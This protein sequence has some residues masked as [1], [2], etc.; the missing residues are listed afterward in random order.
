MI[1]NSINRRFPVV[2]AIILFIFILIPYLFWRGTWFGTELTPSQ[3]QQYLADK[4]KPRKVQHALVQIERKIVEGDT[5]VRRLYP[6]VSKLSDHPS[7]EV[8]I[9]AA[10]VMGQ[11]TSYAPFHQALLK[12]LRDANPTVGR[13]AALSLVRFHDLSG[14]EEILSMLRPYPVI[15]GSEGTATMIVSA[16]DPCQHGKLLARIQHALGTADVQAP[17]SGSVGDLLTHTGDAVAAG[18]TLLTILPDENQIWEALRALYL[19]GSREDLPM[20]SKYTS[21]NYPERIQ[22]QAKE[23]VLETQRHAR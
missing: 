1:A 6:Q 13:N 21:A 10:W 19:I 14:K 11:D 17:I 18:Q 12:L 8:R 3:M 7:K 15:A 22:Q 16:G 2:S 4:D 23:T 9:T 20:I 5:A